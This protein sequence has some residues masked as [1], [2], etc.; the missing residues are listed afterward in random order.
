MQPFLMHELD[1]G[2]PLLDAQPDSAALLSSQVFD[3]SVRERC[4]SR[5]GESVSEFGRRNGISIKCQGDS[6]EYVLRANG[7][8]QTLFKT[9]AT[10]QGLKD[11]KKLL[12]RLVEER[13]S[14]IEQRYCVSV[15]RQDEYI[16]KMKVMA[17]QSSGIMDVFARAPKLAELAGLESALAKSGPSRNDLRVY[18][19]RDMYPRGFG[20]FAY[21]DTDP[22]GRPAIF[23]QPGVEERPP[24]ERDRPALAVLSGNLDPGTSIEALV[25]HEIAH[26]HQLRMGWDK[27]TVVTEVAEKMGWKPYVG[28]KGDTRYLLISNE[29]DS[30]GSP[31]LYSNAGSWILSDANGQA[32]DRAGKPVE[33]LNTVTLS[34][35]EMIARAAIKPATPYFRD[36]IEMYAEALM[37]LRLGGDARKALLSGSPGLYALVKTRDQDEIDGEH[38]PGQF[39]RSTSGELIPDTQANRS[40]ITSWETARQ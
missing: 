15:A 16:G 29:V 38:G 12:D 7:S 21:Y 13:T 27:D 26:R 1:R 32:I 37:L 11:A 8:E 6:Y 25:T 35:E 22:S 20:V 23:L 39:I 14:D 9:A 19:V 3:L 17:A 10:E 33:P 24:T 36:P 2:Q 31:R 5:L 4:E 34:N 30:S 18:F 28:R 40:S